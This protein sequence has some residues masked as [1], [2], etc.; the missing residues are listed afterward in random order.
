MVI[1][2]SSLF[3]EII[4]HTIYK[5]GVSQK[6]CVKRMSIVYVMYIEM[7]VDHR[8]VGLHYATLNEPEKH[9]NAK[10]QFHQRWLN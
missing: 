9:K 10:G 6:D 2:E 5:N 7:L 8:V 1:A 3:Q 4:L